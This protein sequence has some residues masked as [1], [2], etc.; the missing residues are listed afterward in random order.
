LEIE[1]EIVKPESIIEIDRKVKEIN[2]EYEKRLKELKELKNKILTEIGNVVNEF[3]GS[4]SGEIIAKQPKGFE[5]IQV[6]FGYIDVGKEKIPIPTIRV[7]EELLFWNDVGK[8]KRYLSDVID[9]L[10][11]LESIKGIKR[12]V[13]KLVRKAERLKKFYDNVVCSVILLYR[14]EWNKLPKEEI[15]WE[16]QGIR[17]IKIRKSRFKQVSNE[18]V[19]GE[20]YIRI[21]VPKKNFKIEESAYEFLKLMKG[22]NFMKEFLGRYAY[23]DIFGNIDVVGL[24][25]VKVEKCLE[26]IKKE[27]EIYKLMKYD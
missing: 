17:V 9:C 14:R 16:E 24:V 12:D 6:G 2:D 5:F 4:M 21:E 10:S 22:D 1:K 7:R 8:L 19:D 27:I 20:I 15:V 3:G 26:D 25:A 13:K 23:L 11:V 18:E